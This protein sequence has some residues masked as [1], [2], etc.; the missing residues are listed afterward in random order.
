MA[1]LERI[2]RPVLPP[3]IRPS[4]PSPSATVDD[5]EP[6]TLS[7]KGNN[8]ISLSHSESQN[9]SADRKEW[10]YKIYDVVRIYD[11]KDLRSDADRNSVDDQVITFL[12]MKDVSGVFHDYRY[13]SPKNE[14]DRAT[15]RL[16]QEV[17]SRNNKEY[18]GDAVF[19][20]R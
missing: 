15:G 4:D 19:K 1:G 5:S 17:L 13:P 12:R 18:I 8:P 14:T 11:P 16:T 3:S 2:V 9:W 7:G 6:I 20:T 10:E